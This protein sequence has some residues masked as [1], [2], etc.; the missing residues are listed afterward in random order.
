MLEF[1]QWGP[2]LTF[3]QEL[4]PTPNCDKEQKEL[5]F[6][7]NGKT[8]RDHESLVAAAEQTG[9]QT[10]IVSDEQGLPHNYN[11][12]C[13]FLGIAFCIASQAKRLINI[14]WSKRSI[15]MRN[16]NGG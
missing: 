7:S 13:A 14:R 11:D 3:Y 16:G 2:D 8:R 4:A 12:K 10:I 15:F 6:I 1:M 5:I 9:N